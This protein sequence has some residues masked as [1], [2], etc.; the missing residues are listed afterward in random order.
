MGLSGRFLTIEAQLQPPCLNVAMQCQTQNNILQTQNNLLCNST[1]GGRGP[2]KLSQPEGIMRRSE[3]IIIALPSGQG[4]DQYC[5]AVIAAVLKQ[6][7]KR[8]GQ[9]SAGGRI[10]QVFP[11]YM[12]PRIRAVPCSIVFCKR[13]S[14]MSSLHVFS[15]HF[16]QFPNSRQTCCLFLLA[17]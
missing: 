3:R 9:G 14:A 13:K 15:G 4:M 5:W 17:F 1:R 11:S 16:L 6:V 7:S 10:F 12:H 2:C 8:T